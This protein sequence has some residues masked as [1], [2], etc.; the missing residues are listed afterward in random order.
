MQYLGDTSPTSFFNPDT[1]TG[2]AALGFAGGATS[3]LLLSAGTCAFELV[4][5][6]SQLEYLIA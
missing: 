1:L 2:R 5:I 4:K 3:G 6:R